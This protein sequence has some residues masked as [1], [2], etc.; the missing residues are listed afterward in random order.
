[1][2]GWHHDNAQWKPK[3][4]AVCSAMFTPKSG[5]H[6]FCSEQCKG[7]WQYITG[8]GS[9]DNQYKTISG[10]WRK[11]YMRL[12]QR[13]DRKEDGLTVEHLMDMHERQQGLCALSGIQLTCELAKGTVCYTN[14]SI[15]RKE[16]GGVYSPSNIQLV[17]SHVNSWRG[18]VPLPIFIS[19]CRAIAAK[20]EGICYDN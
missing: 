1:M 9:T 8:S 19:V 14:A 3:N 13:K 6:K 11:Y 18:V 2:A 7:K 17:C 5:V 20:H 10:N 4:C 15:D 16:A 12:L